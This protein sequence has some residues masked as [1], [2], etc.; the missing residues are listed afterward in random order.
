L[1]SLP[2]ALLTGHVGYVTRD[3]YAIFYRDAVED[4]AAFQAGFPVRLMEKRPAVVDAS[5]LGC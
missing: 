1:R 5:L 3:L 4:I 2:N